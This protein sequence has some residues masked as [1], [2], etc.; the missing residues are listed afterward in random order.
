MNFSKMNDT[1]SSG[2]YT[3]SDHLLINY[4]V[5]E[6]IG[7]VIGNILKSCGFFAGLQL[8]SVTLNDKTVNTLEKTVLVPLNS[9]KV[10]IVF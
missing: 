7:S 10:S 5:I 3:Q 1:V 4:W 9:K 8:E 2:R 6:R